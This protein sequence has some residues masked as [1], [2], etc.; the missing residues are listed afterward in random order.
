[1]FKLSETIDVAAPPQA[2]FD[3]VVDVD[4]IARWQS[5]VFASQMLTPPPA[6][7]GTRFTETLKLMG[8][9]LTSVCEV[10]ELTAPKTYA[11]NA[12]GSQMDY[13]ARFDFAPA[14]GGGT[15]ITHQ[16]T[17][18]MRGLWKLIEPMVRAE[19]SKEIKEEFRKLK[20]AM[21]SDAAAR[22]PL[23]MAA[24]R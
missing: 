13:T 21:E 6:R 14:P 5:G 10:T 7:V 17:I 16:A 9:K 12:Q 22:P 4:N 24:S 23:K 19:G 1:M 8:L 20:S 18:A 2:A 15:R 11:F 3:W